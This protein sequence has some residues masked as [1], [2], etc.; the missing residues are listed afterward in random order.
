M[1][2]AAPS[3]AASEPVEAYLDQLLL[4]LAGP[5]RQVRH[6]LAE[7]EAHLYDAVAEELAG[8]RSSRPRPR[9]RPGGPVWPGAGC[10]RPGRAI[11][12]ARCSAWRGAAPWP[13][14]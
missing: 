12:P 11:A 8:G 10:H 3:P 9:P 13:P 2:E 1:N 6:T 14:H 4:V 7:I 5:P